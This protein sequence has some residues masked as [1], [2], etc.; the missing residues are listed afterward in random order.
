MSSFGWAA[1]GVAVAAFVVVAVVAYASR[2]SFQRQLAAVAERFDERA[3][4]RTPERLDSVLEQM[5]RSVNGANERADAFE[6]ERDRLEL[7]IDAA[8]DGVVVVDARGRVVYRNA[9]AERYHGARHAD[10]L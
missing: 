8:N 2:R 3:D 5:Q 9:A 1:L 10:L 4:V 6:R 7:A